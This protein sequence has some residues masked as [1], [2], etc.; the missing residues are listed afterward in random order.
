MPVRFLRFNLRSSSEPVRAPSLERLLACA[1]ETCHSVDW[2]ADAFAVLT[3]GAGPARSSEPP[4]PLGPLALRASGIE[5]GSTSAGAG[6]PAAWVCLATPVHYLAE[7]SNVRFAGDGILSLDAAEAAALAQDF[8][9]LWQGSGV[10]LWSVARRLFCGFD[11]PLEVI[12]QDP[13]SARGRH[14]HSFLPTG[15]DAPQLRRLMSEIEMWLF[16]HAVNDRRKTQSVLPIS[17]LW[18]WGGGA[19][20]DSLPAVQGG[21]AGDDVLA[22]AYPVQG[23]RPADVMVVEMAPG[24]PTWAELESTWLTPTLA[25]LRRGQI[26]RLDLSAGERR[27][28]VSA[29]WRRRFWRRAKPW[30]EYFE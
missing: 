25:A 23:N 8:N 5:P 7:L 29:R 2:R 12:T 4:P 18:L 15:R 21:V 19:P 10:H 6:L 30:W 24:S 20:L 16:E 26:T 17:G 14:L 9:A 3:S 1:D 13:E 11:A 28:T 27:F 22:E